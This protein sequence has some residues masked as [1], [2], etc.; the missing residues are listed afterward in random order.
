VLRTV[1]VVVLLSFGGLVSLANWAA[2]VQSML[3]R[4]FVSAVPLFGAA[5]LAAG[6][7]LHPRSRPYAWLAV[8]LDYGT[9]ALL[10]ALP[11]LIREAQ[12]KVR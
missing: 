6:L 11:R 5:L 7:L 9:L 2:L 8:V 1:L 12:R 3:R 4:R 10:I